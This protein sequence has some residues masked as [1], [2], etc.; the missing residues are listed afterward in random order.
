MVATKDIHPDVVKDL[1]PDL[2]KTKVSIWYGDKAIEIDTGRSKP[3]GEEDSTAQGSGSE[4]DG[5]P[6]GS[7]GVT[8]SDDGKIT[9]AVID[10]G[11]ETTS[12]L[13]KALRGQLAG[14]KAENETLLK[15]RD[16][17]LTLGEKMLN[18]S[19]AIM[20]KVASLPVGRKTQ[21]GAFADQD[22]Q[23]ADDRIDA[24]GALYD[25]E[26]RDLITGRRTAR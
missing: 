12:S 14:A 24:L 25:K 15:E 21:S 10:P 1:H 3:K 13:V 5:S 22:L 8:K 26:V 4:N 2:S 19:R 7:S 18:E 23:K 17:A 11:S 16:A 20:T 9:T 6:A